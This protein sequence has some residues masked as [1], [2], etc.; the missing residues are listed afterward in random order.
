MMALVNE[1]RQRISEQASALQMAYVQQ[2]MQLLRQN[3]EQQA[4]ICRLF[5][6]VTSCE[7]AGTTQIEDVL[8]KLRTEPAIPV[9][10][11][12]DDVVPQAEPQGLEHIG[13][14][15][16]RLQTQLGQQLSKLSQDVIRERITRARGGGAAAASSGVGPPAWSVASSPVAETPA[17]RAYQ[18]EQDAR[19]REPERSAKKPQPRQGSGEWRTPEQSVVAAWP[20]SNPAAARSPPTPEVQSERLSDAV[21]QQRSK[22]TSLSA[23]EQECLTPLQHVRS[24]L[25]G[26]SLASG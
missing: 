10:V 8:R 4:E 5:A 9:L 1:V 7:K 3:E 6:L 19:R 26:R 15:I 16:Q 17:S 18:Y 20:P 11:T 13:Q 12:S 2:Y 25:S 22:P 24:L 23:K 14:Q 21:Q